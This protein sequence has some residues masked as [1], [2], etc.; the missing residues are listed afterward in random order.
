MIIRMNSGGLRV[1]R[2]GHRNLL[3]ARLVGDGLG[4]FFWSY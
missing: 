3:T 1:G 4:Q 2:G